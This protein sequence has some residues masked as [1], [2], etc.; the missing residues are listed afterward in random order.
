MGGLAGSITFSHAAVP[1]DIR[2]NTG[3]S[4]V[5]V[6]FVRKADQFDDE[7]GNM[8]SCAACHNPHAADPAINEQWI[9]SGHGDLT[10]DPWTHY[11]W[12][13]KT[14]TATMSDRKACQR[15]HTSTGFRN[16]AN[17]P[18][19]YDPAYNDFSYLAPGTADGA[20]LDN[21]QNETLYCWACHTDYKGT[22]RNP[23]AIDAMY[24]DMT[25]TEVIFP[26][27]SSSNVCIACHKGRESGGSITASTNNFANTG[28]I[29]S[30]YLGAGGILFT[31]IGYEYYPHS[32]LYD[33]VSYYEHDQI[34]RTAANTGTNGPC[35]GCHMEFT[36]E[37]HLF[38]PVEHDP[39]TDQMIAITSTVC[40]LCH[41]GQYEMTV[42][43]LNEEEEESSDAKNALA[44]LL[45]TNRGYYYDPGH[46]P[47][48]FLGPYDPTYVEG[49]ANPHCQKNLPVKNWLTGGTSTFA[50]NGS[51]CVSTAV[52][53]L[54]GTGK[55]KMGAAFNLQV[56]T[57][58]VGSYV[59]NRYYTKRL[60]YDAIDR[61]DNNILDDS[62]KTTL[63]GYPDTTPWKANALTYLL[64]NPNCTPDAATHA[65]R[66]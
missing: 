35:V 52:G 27:I 51:S 55:N 12:K 6:L 20:G 2:Q 54:A 50:W 59:H 46:N 58:E 3:P 1:G 8:G 37:K 33:N 39:V 53:G 22:R 13:S 21:G 19:G 30:H 62:V 34:G 45:Q 10:G 63:N 49:T 18:T 38:L 60:I 7:N 32:P 66:P 28:F 9:R 14:K 56:V 36:A 64:S 43:K 4:A 24:K 41:T 31:K 48:F 40:A 44:D 17:N 47:Y 42:D 11:N 26:D 5:P 23:G 29:N 16:F 57:R 25:G 15:C 65:C 61:T